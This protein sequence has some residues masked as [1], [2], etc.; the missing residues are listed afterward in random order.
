MSP[1]PHGPLTFEFRGNPA[2]ESSCRPW[3]PAEECLHRLHMGCEAFPSPR[4]TLN[5][6]CVTSWIHSRTMEKIRNGHSLLH[7]FGSHK[8]IDQRAT[9]NPDCPVTGLWSCGACFPSISIRAASN[10]TTYTQTVQLHILKPTAN[11]EL[12]H[13]LCYNDGSKSI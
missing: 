12:P 1:A 7:S 11:A 13:S 9:L 10:V 3:V 8:D 4:K 6:F 5:I 2:E